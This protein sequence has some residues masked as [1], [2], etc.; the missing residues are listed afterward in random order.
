M[1]QI[2]RSRISIVVVGFDSSA[3]GRQASSP[4]RGFTPTSD[5]PSSSGPCC[6]TFLT[7][8]PPQ[9]QRMAGRRLASLIGQVLLCLV[10]GELLARIYNRA[11]DASS[12][13]KLPLHYPSVGC[14]IYHIKVTVHTATNL[15]H[16]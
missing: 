4:L 13:V 5:S 10:A 6:L 1:I 16:V 14:F 8:T 7:S 12:S 11:L 9:P 2:A 15:G 3:A